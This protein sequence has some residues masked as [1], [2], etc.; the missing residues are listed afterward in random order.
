[1]LLPRGE[2]L[3]H[4]GGFVVQFHYAY[5]WNVTYVIAV[6]MYGSSM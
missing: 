3:V 6:K 2:V 1:V 4:P 5:I